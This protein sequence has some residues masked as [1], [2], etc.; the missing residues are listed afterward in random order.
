MT[1]STA[2]AACTFAAR[3]VLCLASHARTREPSSTTP[4]L[5]F[6]T[7]ETRPHFGAVIVAPLDPSSLAALERRHLPADKWQEILVVHAEKTTGLAMLGSY[8]VSRDTLRFEPRFPPIRGTSYIA[9]YNG[10][11]FNERTGG[12]GFSSVLSQTWTRP[13]AR[14]TPTTSIVEV[15]PTT[16]SVPMNLLRMYVA[17]LRADD[18]GRRSGETRSPDRRARHRG[19]QRISHRRGRTG[20][21]GRRAHATHDFLR[22]GPHQARSHAARSA[23]TAAASGPY[24][25]P[26]NRQHH[27]R[28]P[29]LA[30]WRVATRSDFASDR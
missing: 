10:A 28:C 11:A 26:R 4:V 30:D 9:R 22:S 2:R 17:I 12:R 29:G 14:G 13:S 6:Q 16:D 3:A 21:V 8:V 19:R 1:R 24:V 20:T 5:S 15:Y 7:D 27:A 25:Q 23:R 18:G